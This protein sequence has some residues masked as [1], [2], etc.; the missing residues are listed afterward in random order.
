MK[1]VYYMVASLLMVG[2]G[3]GTT[4]T[5]GKMPNPTN[6]SLTQ[7]FAVYNQAYQENYE[8]DTLLEIFEDAEDAYV[9]I[10]SFMYGVSKHIPTIKASRNYVSGYISVGTGEVWRDDYSDLEPF[11]A[12]KAWSEHNDEYFIS[13]TNTGVLDVM[14]RR[15]DKMSEDGIDWVEFDNMDW[16]TPENKADY[17]LTA[18][19]EQSKVYINSLCDY[20]HAKGMKCMAK[21]TVDGFANFDGVVYE[22]YHFNKN[23]WNSEGTYAFLNA[24]KPVIINHYNE[25]N[26]DGVYKEY[27]NTYMSNKISFICEDIESKKYIHYNQD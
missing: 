10:D 19:V 25:V 15:I 3:G 17:N 16:L 4:D 24:G 23:W 6:K 8:A 12:L 27:K 20:T 14:I 18:T 1:N 21:N 2:C 26:C 5:N 11:L 22:S 13:E 7:P 9:L